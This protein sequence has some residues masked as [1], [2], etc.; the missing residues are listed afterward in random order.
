[1]ALTDWVVIPD[2]GARM[3]T[4]ITEPL[5]IAFNIEPTKKG[6]GVFAIPLTSKSRS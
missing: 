3:T 2:L 5:N 1:M 4:E 6:N